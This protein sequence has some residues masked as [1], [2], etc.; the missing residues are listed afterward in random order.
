MSVNINNDEHNPVTN[1]TMQPTRGIL[2]TS[3]SIEQSQ[4]DNNNEMTSSIDNYPI[5]GMTRSESKR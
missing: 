5:T 3:K 1:L 2:K 4:S